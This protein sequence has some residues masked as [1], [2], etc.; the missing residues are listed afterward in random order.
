M[1][2]HGISIG[3]IDTG[4]TVSQVTISGNTVTSSTNGLRIKTFYGATAASVTG[5]I[6]TG[7]TVSGERHNNAV[8]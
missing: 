5:V 2:G 7:N 3:S 1:L 4:K 8:N 6:Y